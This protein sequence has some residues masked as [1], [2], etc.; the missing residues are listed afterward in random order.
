MIN[1]KNMLTGSG[2]S[3]HEADT[4]N[5]VNKAGGDQPIIWIFCTIFEKKYILLLNQN[6]A[7]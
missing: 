7:S 6:K 2:M 4:G 1:M 5:P 3:I